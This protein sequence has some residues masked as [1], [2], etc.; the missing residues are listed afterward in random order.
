MFRDIK[1]INVRVFK[2]LLTAIIAANFYYLFNFVDLD[3]FNVNAFLTLNTN[4]ESSFFIKDFFLFYDAETKDS[5]Q[6]Q[7]YM[8]LVGSKI[9]III[10]SY[11]L[12]SA[13][14]RLNMLMELSGGGSKVYKK[15]YLL[16]RFYF[17]AQI[18]NLFAYILFANQVNGLP[19]LVY[20]VVIFRIFFLKK[21]N[22]YW[23]IKP[24]L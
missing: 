8:A 12:K 11:L 9:V 16:T 13:L 10:I 17:F 2:W 19:L 15:S 7:N 23:I 3:V 6:M 24:E 22:D 4:K 14:F 21:E 18:Y 20:C 1:N 5:L